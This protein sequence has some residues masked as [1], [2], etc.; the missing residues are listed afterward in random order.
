MSF[1]GEQ[2]PQPCGPYRL[3][4]VDL[5]FVAKK[6]REGIERHR[7]QAQ[8]KAEIERKALEDRKRR[9]MLAKTEQEIYDA[10]RAQ[11]SWREF[12]QKVSAMG[13]DMAAANRFYQQIYERV[14][15]EVLA[16]TCLKP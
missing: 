8:R 16:Q 3:P 12:W 6:H 10:F 13:A 15:N 14:R 2:D 5:D 1:R 7:R 9:A 11:F 4:A